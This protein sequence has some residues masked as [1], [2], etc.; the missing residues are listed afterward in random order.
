MVWRLPITAGKIPDLQVR[1][2]KQTKASTL[3]RQ[4]QVNN[5]RLQ[6]WNIE[7]KLGL[8]GLDIQIQGLKSSSKNVLLRIISSE[9]QVITSVLNSDESHYQM[10]EHHSI[11]TETTFFRYTLLGFE[12]ILIGLDHLLFVTCLVYISRTRKNYSGPLRAL[13]L[14]TQSPCSWRLVSY[15]ILLY[16]R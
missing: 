13:R 8:K 9:N 10:V 14:L 1:F 3:I 7:R 2:D 12:H 6:Q 4:Q 15:L 5:A 16:L 11:V